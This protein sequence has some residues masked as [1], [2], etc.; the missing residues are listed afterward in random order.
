M[1]RLIDA[2]AL[3]TYDVSPAYGM[4][5]IGLTEEDIELAPTVDAVPVELIKEMIARLRRRR[6]NL[7]DD[8][9]DEAW[10]LKM[11]IEAL[12]DLLSEW[13]ERREE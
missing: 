6:M 12:D 3:N 9:V 8:C 7:D 5:V 1:T 11:Q 13:A 2:D 4:T 10:D